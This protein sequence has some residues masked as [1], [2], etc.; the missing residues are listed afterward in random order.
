MAPT[1]PPSDRKELGPPALSTPTL[2]LPTSPTTPTTTVQPANKW[3]AIDSAVAAGGFIAGAIVVGIVVCLAYRC[4]Y[5]VNRKTRQGGIE[6]QASHQGWDVR[7]HPNNFD[8]WAANGN[9]VVAARRLREMRDIYNA[10][11]DADSSPASPIHTGPLTPTEENAATADQTLVLPA[12]AAQGGEPRRE[13]FAL[14]ALSR[15]TWPF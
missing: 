3:T 10:P 15:L 14:R 12:D 13:P 5:R 4:F 6:L 7:T 11:A 9:H 8:E 2:A 1:I